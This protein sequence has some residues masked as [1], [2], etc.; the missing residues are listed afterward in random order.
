MSAFRM[1]AL[2]LVAIPMMALSVTRGENSE[3]LPVYMGRTI[4]HTMHWMGADWLTRNER[5]REES[6]TEML[7]EL[8]LTPGMVV[9]D[10]GCGNGFHTLPMAEK[11]APGGQVF[12]VDIQ[13]EMLTFLKKRAEEAKV[14]NIVPLLGEL[15]NPKLPPD[16]C[17][18]ILLVDAYHEFSNPEAMLKGM[19]EALKADGLIALVEFRAEDPKVPIKPDHKMSRDQILKEYTANGFAL[20]RS[21]DQLPWQ[22]LMFFKKTE[23]PVAP[24]TP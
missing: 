23:P 8:R 7:R 16:S 9:A 21:Y 14:S 1:R 12:G 18:L 17:D 6:T 24:Q 22:H 3:K 10:L 11:V 15:E 2:G 4:A 20:A 19:R 5:A 13:P